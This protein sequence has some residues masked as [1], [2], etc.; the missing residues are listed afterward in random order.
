[1]TGKN[2]TGTHFGV[3]EVVKESSKPPR[4]VPPEF[5]P[6][7]TPIMQSF[8][9]LL[10]SPL[11]IHRPAV[12]K[13]YLANGP[14][15]R[16]QRGSDEFVELDW[17]EALD[18]AAKALR[19]TYDE[20]GPASVFGGSYGW[21]SAGRFH[22]AQSQIHR[23]LNC[24]G[25]YTA[26]VNTYSHAA[27]EVLLPHIVGREDDII[28]SGTTWPVI[29]DHTKLI[30]A[31]GGLPSVT[32][33][34]SPGGVSAHTNRDWISQCAKAGTRLVTIGPTRSHVDETLDSDWIALRPNTDTALMLALAYQL[35]VT[36][37]CDH[38]FL[39]RYTVG[40]ENFRPYLMGE[41]DGQPKTPEWA[42]RICNCDPGVI[43]ELAK[44]MTTQRTLLCATW[45]LQRAHH[46]EQP[47]WMLIVLAAMLG[48]IGL[49]G[50]GFS[51]GIS[52]FNGVANPVHRRRYA[53]LSQGKNP[54]LP[55]IPVARITELLETPGTCI[56]YNGQKI[57]F[58]EIQMIYWAGGNPFHHHQDLNRLRKAWRRPRTVIV[59]EIEWNGVARHAD[60]VFPVASVLERNDVMAPN[61]DRRIV[62][63][64]KCAD[65]VGQSKTDFEIFSGLAARLDVAERFTGG[66][67]EHGWISHMYQKSCDRFQA[68]GV[69]LP[70]FE[71]FW[72]E[73]V[74]EHCPDT[75]E[76]T[77]LADF[78]RNPQQYPLSTPSG[79][80]EIFSQTIAGFEYDDCPGHPTWMPP[81]EWLGHDL[82]TTYPLHLMSPQPRNRLHGQLDGNGVSAASKIRGR[83]PAYLSPS[84]AK[85]RGIKDKDIIRVF[86]ATGAT[87]CGARVVEW[88]ADHIIVLPTGAWYSPKN[89]DGAFCVHGNPNVLTQDAP[90]SRLSQ[91]PSPN[92]TLVEAELFTGALPTVTAHRPPVNPNSEETI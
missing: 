32:G 1:M 39:E 47:F 9:E 59:N 88:V 34:V 33:Q 81:R 70:D 86:N 77:L 19:D 35:V 37:N 91:G 58:P 15:S 82:R 20:F 74:Y 69:E 4:L 53:S 65:P 45:A 89:N 14:A 31:F 80:I 5:D 18:L 52:S 30:V 79:R 41:N 44:Q 68:F 85:S 50:G 51:F 48:Q 23:F 73:G 29:R 72:K 28:Y 55:R 2:Y 84:T 75:V 7:P 36:G 22:H 56:D 67:D 90:T 16:E 27:A 43:V 3:F 62:A 17:E 6:D 61:S 40:F 76:R 12:R 26:S 54:V 46:G 42:A 25:G 13:G 11:R 63:L 8:G 21:S 49:P 60:I 87:L 92:S 64:K 38:R 24:L 66:R 78:R 71:T 10:T 83:E 57:T